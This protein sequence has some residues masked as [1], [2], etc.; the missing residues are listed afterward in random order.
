[1]NADNTQTTQTTAPAHM[2]T[3]HSRIVVWKQVFVSGTLEGIEIV[4][5]L[6]FGDSASAYRWI[7]GV[8]A[9]IERGA[10]P[11]RFVDDRFGCPAVATYA[12]TTRQWAEQDFQDWHA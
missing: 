5:S 4:Q 6:P 2:T 1:M 9:N 11:W 12:D 7:G 3:V 10:L 8:K